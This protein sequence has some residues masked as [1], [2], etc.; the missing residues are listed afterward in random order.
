L[1]S[2]KDYIAHTIFGEKYHVSKD[3]K[4]FTRLEYFKLKCKLSFQPSMFPYNLECRKTNHWVLWNYDKNFDYSEEEINEI[5]KR[6][7]FYHT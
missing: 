6:N 3:F 7:L 1:K 2:P 4:K 5:I